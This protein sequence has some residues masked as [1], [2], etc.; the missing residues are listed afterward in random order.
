MSLKYYF[1]NE[2]LDSR[3]DLNIKI[4]NNRMGR[5]YIIDNKYCYE[6]DAKDKEN[7]TK[8]NDI[9]FYQYIKNK[10]PELSEDFYSD[11]VDSEI[12]INSVLK[13]KAYKCCNM[14]IYTEDAYARVEGV[15]DEEAYF[16]YNDPITRAISSFEYMKNNNIHSELIQFCVI[17]KEYFEWLENNSLVDNEN[18]R[19][20]YI[21]GMTKETRERLW[22]K[23]SFGVDIVPYVIPV[24]YLYGSNTATS[25]DI[26][27][28]D[29]VVSSL[30]SDIADNQ[31]ISKDDIVIYPYAYRADYVVEKEDELFNNICEV[32]HNGEKVISPNTK[33]Y[34]QKES[35]VNVRF[36]VVG[37]KKNHSPIYSKIE[38]LEAKS[39]EEVI[40]SDVTKGLIKE[41]DNCIGCCVEDMLV[42]IDCI[43]EFHDVLVQSID[44]KMK[45]LNK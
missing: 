13:L 33:L 37:I 2:Q 11:R 18:N 42:D 10:K 44:D 3:E 23:Y 22:Y 21:D 1:D 7:V 43:D 19:I 28:S 8:L 29:K 32:S 30:K 6:L 4:E 5:A 38:V 41:S 40:F 24:V 9:E 12:E 45:E 25:A 14:S 35:N 20:K 16:I 26:K 27:L 31:Y 34:I 17:D 15:T 39:I 36:I